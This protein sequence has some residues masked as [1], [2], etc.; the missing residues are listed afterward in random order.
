MPSA[1]ECSHD[2]RHLGF[3][4]RINSQK[5]RRG[6]CRAGADEPT[7]I[8][9]R[10]RRLDRGISTDGIDESRDVRA[11][12]STDGRVNA[13]VGLVIGR[14][15]LELPGE[16]SGPVADQ[17][18]DHP[19]TPPHEDDNGEVAH[20]QHARREDAPP[21][22]SPEVAPPDPPPHTRGHGQLRPRRSR[23]SE[24]NEGSRPISNARSRY[25]RS[26]CSSG[27]STGRMIIRAGTSRSPIRR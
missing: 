22:V 15:D 27:L 14:V 13:L 9:A 11:F 1:V 4:L 18:G 2:S 12:T 3:E 21:S 20:R 24:K 25:R 17:L 19:L 5:H 23:R 26:V 7:T 6:G 16:N 8:H 10:C